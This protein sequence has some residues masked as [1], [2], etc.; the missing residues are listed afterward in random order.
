MNKLHLLKSLIPGFLPIIVFIVVDELM[1]TLYGL[2]TAITIGIAE[3]VITYI[4]DKR[5][6]RFILFDVGLILALGG[7]SIAL[8]N[9]IFFK[10]KPGIISLIMT[11]L[12]GFS[13]YSKHNVL[14]QMTQRYMKN[15]QI[16][17]YQTWLMQQS[18]RRI[19]WILLLFSIATIV[20]SFVENKAVWSFLNS[21]GLFIVMALFLLYEW[22]NN[23]MKSKKQEQEEWLPIVNEQ[24]LITGKAPRSVVHAKSFLQHP[25]V[26][27]H[28]IDNNKILLQKRPANKLIQANKWDTAVGGHVASGESI[29]LALY[30]ETK[31]E[32]G[33]SEFKATPID[34]Y[35]WESEIEKELVFVFKLSH[36][37]PFKIDNNE[38]TELRFWSP[39]EIEEQLGK[40]IF[41]PNFEIEYK[42][43]AQLLVKT[44]A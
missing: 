9:E 4:K 33:I 39:K 18:M 7:V 21:V 24:G 11:A 20:S 38:V 40:C 37:G 43:Y 23:K 10:L 35:T 36:K 25:V 41:T 6:E 16:N 1:G 22:I 42:K 17:P 30:R 2:V 5:I 13:V 26:H 29:E 12:I 44:P 15:I 3:L 8:D 19:F 34:Q 32:I 14:M 27:L 28:V 31:E